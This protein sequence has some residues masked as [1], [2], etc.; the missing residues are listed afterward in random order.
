M[1]DLDT[2][3]NSLVNI[4]AKASLQLLFRRKPPSHLSVLLDRRTASQDKTTRGSN[5]LAGS[6]G[7]CPFSNT[8]TLHR[9]CLRATS[10]SANPLNKS[11]RARGQPSGPPCA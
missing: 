10:N 7:S 9:T 3:L 1:R 5:L 8:A 4:D 6:T 2:L 11:P